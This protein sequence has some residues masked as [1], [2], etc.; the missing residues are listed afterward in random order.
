MESAG[1]RLSDPSKSSI[2]ST[3]K[4][5]SWDR[6]R[7]AR[8]GFELASRCLSRV[9]GFRS[10]TGTFLAAI[11]TQLHS[12]TSCGPEAG[13]WEPMKA[14][15]SVHSYQVVDFVAQGTGSLR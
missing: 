9:S 1:V 14:S 12:V 2:G 6:S 4:S 11:Q 13:R 5:K 7:A 10:K 8:P 3:S 15:Q